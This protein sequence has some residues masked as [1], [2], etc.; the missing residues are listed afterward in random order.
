MSTS[1]WLLEFGYLME[2][3]FIQHKTTHDDAQTRRLCVF[4]NIDEEGDRA[5]ILAAG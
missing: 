3:W 5:A 2:F 1:G 4:F